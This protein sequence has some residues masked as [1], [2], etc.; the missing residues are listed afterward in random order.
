MPMVPGFTYDHEDRER[1]HLV[2]FDD[3][4]YELHCED[5]VDFD[6]DIYVRFERLYDGNIRMSMDHHSFTVFTWTIYDANGNALM[7][8]GAGSQGMLQTMMLPGQ[9]T[10]CGCTG[11]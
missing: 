11:M 8:L 9:G 7:T 2:F 6:W 4:R 1:V 10:H 5:Y 3:C